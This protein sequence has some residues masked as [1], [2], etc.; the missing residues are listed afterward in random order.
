M[1]VLFT[2]F[3][4]FEAKVATRSADRTSHAKG[5]FLSTVLFTSFAHF[6]ANV[7]TRSA[8]RISHAKGGRITARKNAIKYVAVWSNKGHG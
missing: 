4:H 5:I 7:V 6:E 2:S 3:A 8:D 1:K